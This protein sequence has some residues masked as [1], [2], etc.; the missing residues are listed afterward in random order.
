MGGIPIQRPPLDEAV[1]TINRAIDLGVNFIDTSIGYGDSEVRIGKAI[2]GRRNEVIIATKGS[3]G[4]QVKTLKSIEDSLRRL[5]I[6][7]IDLWQFHGVSTK[8]EIDLILRK[9]GGLNGAREALSAGKIDHIGFSSH[10][11]DIAK[12]LI[13]T[14]L[15]ETVQFPFDFVAREAAD[16]IIPMAKKHDMGFIAMKPFAGG[17]IRDAS[18]AIRYLLQFDNVVPDPGIEKAE[19]IEEIA[20]IVEGPWELTE[21]DW[22]DIERIRGELNG[23][24]CRQCMYCMPCPNGVQVWL[25]T[26]MKNLYRL[27]PRELFLGRPIFAEAAESGKKCVRCGVCETRCPYKL[28]IREMIEE[29]MDIYNRVAGGETPPTQ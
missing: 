3:A 16:E 14:D 11:P 12:R 21:V 24:F 6:N 8:E 18:L 1:R 2:S 10:N 27:W 22:K 9:D 25:L 26:Y 20:K 23:K 5:N 28:P 7:N 17:N 29:S 13:E 19:E 15:F 4:D